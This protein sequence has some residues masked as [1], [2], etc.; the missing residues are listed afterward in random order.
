MHEFN[1]SIYIL[2]ELECFILLSRV[3]NRNLKQKKEQSSELSV[4]EKCLSWWRHQ[5]ETFSA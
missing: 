2:N 1:V 5:M 4:H 3:N